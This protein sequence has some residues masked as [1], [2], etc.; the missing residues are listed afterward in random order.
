MLNSFLVKRF[1]DQPH[2]KC[3]NNYFGTNKLISRSTNKHPFVKHD[4]QFSTITERKM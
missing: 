2:R 3:L 1:P 4:E